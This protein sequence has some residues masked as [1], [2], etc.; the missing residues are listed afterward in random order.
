MSPFI[1]AELDLERVS[2]GKGFLKTLRLVPATSIEIVGVKFDKGNLIPVVD[3]EATFEV[4]LNDD[5]AR[6][7]DKNELRT[8]LAGWV[9]A[10]SFSWVIDF[11][12]VEGKDLSMGSPSE[13]MIVAE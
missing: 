1:H 6:E 9:N 7:F 10:I 3:L 8:I 2:L 5:G 4:I 11:W 13:C 12:G